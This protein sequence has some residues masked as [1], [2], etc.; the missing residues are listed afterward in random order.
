MLSKS[1]S[2]RLRFLRLLEA[3]KHRYDIL[4]FISQGIT[5]AVLMLVPLSGL[6]QVDFWGG[7]HYLFFKPAE[8]KLALAGVVVG[9]IAMYVV[10]FL[11]NIVAGRVFCGWGC[12]VGQVSRF[13][14]Q[15]EQKKLPVK[16]MAWNYIKGGLF[17]GV[18]VVSVLAWWVDLKMLIFGD[19]QSLAVG[20]GLVI[21]G[22]TG[23]LLHGKYW[24]WEFCKQVC[25]VG[26]YYSIVAPAKYFGIHFRNDA[27]TC[28]ECSGCD[29]VCPVGLSPRELANAVTDERGFSANAAP[30]FNHCLE[31]GDCI[32]ACDAMI[33]K[34]TPENYPQGVPLKMGYFSGP[35]RVT[36]TVSARNKK[37][38]TKKNKKIIKPN[39]TSGSMK[40]Q[41]ADDEFEKNSRSAG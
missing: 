9:I 15:L 19:L 18:M 20:W 21:F 28:I 2:V 17:S 36:V 40:I 14:E 24:R 11:L 32:Q 27:D 5:L 37:K 30:G 4:R 1:Q 7:N 29:H 8:F 3:H 38:Q 39:N 16:T 33:H 25:P 34:A 22:T 13:G 10:T 31:C 35:Q 6:A 12:P 23:A 26:L 41:R